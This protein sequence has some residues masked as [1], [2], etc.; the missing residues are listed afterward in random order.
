VVPEATT[1]SSAEGLVVEG[2]GWY[3]LNARDA[4]W[5][6]RQSFGRTCL[7]EAEPMF[8]IF[9]QLGFRV[10]VLQPGEPNGM[11][12]R[13]ST[14]EDFLVVA[15]ECLLL[16]EEQERRLK[17]WDFVHCPPE[18]D[19]I[20]VGAGDAPC[21]LVMVGARLP[22]STIVYPVSDLAARHRASVETETPE[23][24]EAY[25]RFEPAVGPYRVGDLPD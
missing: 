20:F 12:H 9:E 14:Q 8:T 6:Q 18:T 24:D 15:G 4:R 13:E 2:D 22:D 1:R 17:Q 11:Y 7:L 21:V 3:V 5:R 25:A 19:H 23:P 10:A 16:I